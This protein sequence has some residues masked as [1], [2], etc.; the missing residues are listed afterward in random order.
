MWRCLRVL[1][2]SILV[3]NKTTTG[4]RE[5]RQKEKA[6]QSLNN[7]KTIMCQMNG[8]KFEFIILNCTMCKLKV[9]PL[10]LD[11]ILPQKNS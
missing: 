7:A 1:A 3:T 8:V 6:L 4:R 2:S 9:V 11:A 10:S 5:K